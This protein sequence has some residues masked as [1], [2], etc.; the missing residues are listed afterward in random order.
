MRAARDVI[1]VKGKPTRAA[2]ERPRLTD[3]GSACVFPR[4]CGNVVK[5][6]RTKTHLIVRSITSAFV[7][8]SGQRA[9]PVDK[10]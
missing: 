5:A 4:T 3:D 2:G 1:T 8:R 7:K 6:R 9:R 10:K